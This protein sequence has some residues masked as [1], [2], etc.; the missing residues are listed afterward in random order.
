MFHRKTLAGAALV[1]ALGLGMPALAQTTETPPEAIE[2]D[3]AQLDAFVLAYVEVSDLREQY[4][5]QLQE[6]QSEEDQQAIME[7]AN[8]EIT[9]AV[10]AVD[11]MDVNTY[12]TIL[13]Q[14]QNDPDLVNRINSR[15]ETLTDE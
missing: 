8:A 12:E 7:E 9:S 11:G 15:I 1:A 5:G 10:D 13:A 6:A 3:S 2:V 4:I 14:A